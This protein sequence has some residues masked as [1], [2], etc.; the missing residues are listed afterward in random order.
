MSATWYPVRVDV[1]VQ[2]GFCDPA[3]GLHVPAAEEIVPA[4]ARLNADA[5]A[6]GIPLIGSVDSHDFSSPEFEQNGGPWPTHCV[7]G[8][9]D[10]L[11]PARTLPA[12]F[13]IVGR[14]PADA[15]AAFEDGRAALYFEKDAYSLFDNVNVPPVLARLEALAASRRARLRFDV[16]GV[17]TDFCV[18]A[19][20]EGLLGR[21]YAVRL[22]ADAARAVDPSRD[23]A[24][25]LR[26]AGTEIASA[27]DVG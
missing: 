15:L 5:M 23:W 19:A 4:V 16:Y 27:A 3:G 22:L 24:G 10:W 13:R 12:R 21:G 17:A 25:V 6:R 8:T 26:E 20:I 7:K 1:D 2:N 11:K 9:W 18:K 14:D